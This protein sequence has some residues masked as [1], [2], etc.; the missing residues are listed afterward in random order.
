MSERYRI[1]DLPATQFTQAYPLIQ[2]TGSAIGLEDWLRHAERLIRGR[3]PGEAGIVSLQT[4]RGYIHG[5]FLYSIDQCLD[6]GRVLEAE[7]VVAPEIL[8]RSIAATLIEAIIAHARLHDCDAIHISLPA[9]PEAAATLAPALRAA[10][11]TTEAVR[12]GRSLR[13]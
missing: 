9:L 4:E 12:L 2:L 13:P 11:F 8:D 6:C 7:T 3:A 1:R 10:G 5:V